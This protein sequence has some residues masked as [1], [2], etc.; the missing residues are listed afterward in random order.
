MT[1]Q[2]HVVL[3]YFCLGHADATYKFKYGLAA[4]SGGGRASARETIGRVAAGA[5]AEKFLTTTFGTVIT[6]FVSSVGQHEIPQSYMFNPKTGEPWSREEIDTLGTLRILRGTA[7]GSKWSKATEAKAQRQIDDVDESL[8]VSNCEKA[9]FPAYVDSTGT[10]YDAQGQLWNDQSIS[11]E[12]N[13]TDEMVPVRC[14]HPPTA[15]KIASLI[16]L[17]KSEQ[18]SIG[19]TVSCVCTNVPPALGEPCFDKLEAMLAHAMLSLPATKGFEIG[20]GFRA[21]SLRGSQHND[22]FEFV[23]GAPG[24][25]RPKTNNAG[26]TL[27]GISSGAP[28]LMRI[29]VKPVSTIGKAQSTCD[30]SGDDAVLEA[31][32]RHDPCVLPRTPPLIES[33]TALVLADAV[34][35]Q[36]TRLSGNRTVIDSDHPENNNNV[37]RIREGN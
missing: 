20:L 10:V 3:T 14:P 2:Q 27:G 25:I 9:S 19:G 33:M 31:K 28:I 11:L 26:G 4:S 30:F 29:A 6:A 13:E 1:Q 21:T 34:L 5:V 24:M 17:V 16:R 12:V 36:R 7:P 22:P 15:C 35:L 18:D 23:E 32:G 8:F 37:K